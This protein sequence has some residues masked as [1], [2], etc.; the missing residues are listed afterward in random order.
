MVVNRGSLA[1]TL[2][3]IAAAPAYAVQIVSTQR[4]TSAASDEYYPRKSGHSIVYTSNRNGNVDIYLYDLDTQ[5]ETNLTNDAA[6]QILDDVQGDYVV[7][8]DYRANPSTGDI[9]AYHVPTGLSCQ[10]TT[11]ASN[12]LY[13]SIANDF[14]AYQDDR[15]GNWDL[16]GFDLTVLD[17]QNFAADCVKLQAGQ[18]VGEAALRIEPGNQL[19][20]ATGGRYVAWQDDRSGALRVYAYDRQTN[21]EVQMPEHG[22][23]QLLPAID[24]SRVVYVEDDGTNRDVCYY[25][26]ATQ[27]FIQITNDPFEQNY[28]NINGNSIAWEDDRNGNL[29]IYLFDL[30]T[31]TVTPLTTD[32]ADQYLNDIDGST[33]VFT[34]TSAGNLD[35]V[36]VTFKPDP[37]PD[38][39]AHAAPPTPVVS[40]TGATSFALDDETLIT[41]RDYTAW[42]FIWWTAKG[43]HA[44]GVSDH[45]RITYDLELAADVP[46][47]LVNL[48]VLLSA[49][50]LPQALRNA[51]L[52]GQG[53]LVVQVN[54]VER[55]WVDTHTGPRT[56][57]LDAVSL[58]GHWFFDAKQDMGAVPF[59]FTLP[60][61]VQ[62]DLGSG[63]TVTFTYAGH[64]AG[65]C[66]YTWADHAFAF[67]SC[68]SG[69]QPGAS[70][71][72][73][74]LRLH[75]TSH[76]ALGARMTLSGTGS[77]GSGEWADITLPDPVPLFKGSN[78]V[79]LSGPSFGKTYDTYRRIDFASGGALTFTPQPVCVPDQALVPICADAKA[80][81]LFGPVVYVR[82][83]GPPQEIDET[84]TAPAEGGG[85]I[86]VQNGDGSG[87]L[88]ATAATMVWNGRPLFPSSSFA[89]ATPALAEPVALQTSNTLATTLQS[90]PGTFI[91][92][93]VVHDTTPKIPIVRIIGCGAVT[94][95]ADTETHSLFLPLCLVLTMAWF[96]RRSRSSRAAAV[97]TRPQLHAMR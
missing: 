72:A 37:P 55:D 31:G 47:A 43:G 45:S 2:L 83:D 16:Y 27:T 42:P 29:D 60:A 67:T 14:V 15:N 91:T 54:G 9:W 79:T 10:L 94:K 26:V 75:L 12:Q 24:G 89:T 66:T 93:K 59:A 88:R 62:S 77:V 87:R 39:C 30:T 22:K 70:L 18:L 90:A 34:D 61:S 13:P 8:T 5:T 69:A 41:E 92:V 3:V 7:W 28:P 40:T 51:G 1:F 4:I 58:G 6:Y 73:T 21:V 36:M 38:P 86:C 82:R 65:A 57:T 20:P 64:D 96:W 76:G 56:A 78:R 33:V 85:V 50:T 52:D 44:T 49:S 53:G 48:H 46:Q 80:E 63:G 25:D 71:S 95:V 84:V 97:R 23:Q 35:V 32:P 68:D 81:V 11:N 17:P 74:Q 19:R